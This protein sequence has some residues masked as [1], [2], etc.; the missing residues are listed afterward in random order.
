[1]MHTT[2]QQLLAVNLDN[3]VKDIVVDYNPLGFCR[4]PHIHVNPLGPQLES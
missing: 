3:Q 2:N 4:V 1:M